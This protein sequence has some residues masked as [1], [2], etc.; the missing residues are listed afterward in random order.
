M[1]ISQEAVRVFYAFSLARND[2]TNC[3]IRGYN[4]SI[5]TQKEKRV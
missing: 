4:N 5:V 3:N 1:L 2:V